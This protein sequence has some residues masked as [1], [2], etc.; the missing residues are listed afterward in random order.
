MP[1]NVIFLTSRESKEDD[2]A[3]FRLGFVTGNSTDC[4]Q[5]FA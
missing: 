3:H 1:D 4:F 2:K 5:F